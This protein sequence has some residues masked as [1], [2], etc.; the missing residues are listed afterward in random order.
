MD[1]KERAAHTLLQQVFT[2]RNAKDKKAA[3][4]N[5]EHRAKRAKVL[6]AE[7][8]SKREGTKLLRKRKYAE[9]AQKDAH[10]ASRSAVGLKLGVGSTS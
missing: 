1:D 4:A 5:A 6:A 7:E 8:A 10:T 3:I 9:M 2:L